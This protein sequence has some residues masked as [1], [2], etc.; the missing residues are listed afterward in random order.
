VDLKAAAGGGEYPAPLYGRVLVVNA[1]G[2]G[3]DER[4]GKWVRRSFLR[5]SQIEN[6]SSLASTSMGEGIVGL[7]L[8]NQRMFPRGYILALRRRPVGGKPCDDRAGA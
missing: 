5:L 2:K 7:G 6:P 4:Q 1:R 3:K 8:C